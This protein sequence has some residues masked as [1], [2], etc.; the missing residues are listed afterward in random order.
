MEGRNRHTDMLKLADAFFGALRQDKDYG[1]WGLDPKR[2]FGFSGSVW[3]DVLIILGDVQ[4]GRDDGDHV[5]TEEQR[6]Y[7][8]NLWNALGGFLK[9][10]WRLYQTIP[11][12][13]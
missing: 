6:E 2:P 12:T 13:G 1:V 9:E 7:A 10:Q 5:W 11:I 3:H 4:Q 8:Q